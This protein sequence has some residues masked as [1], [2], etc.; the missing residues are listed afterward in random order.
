MKE[1][2]F[3]TFVDTLHDNGIKAHS[4]GC[5]DGDHTAHAFIDIEEPYHMEVLENESDKIDI[6]IFKYVTVGYDRE[7]KIIIKHTY[8]TVNG[9]LRKVKELLKDFS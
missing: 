6:T 1:R 4:Y 7:E 9:A 8:K 3:E 5:N 2:L